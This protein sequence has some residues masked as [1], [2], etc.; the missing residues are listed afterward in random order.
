MRRMILASQILLLAACQTSRPAP[1]R[2]YELIRLEYASAEEVSRLLNEPG[3]LHVAPDQRT[4]SMPVSGNQ[5]DVA[6]AKELIVQLDAPLEQQAT[7]ERSF[8]VIAL[9]F[10]D[11][12]E[13]A[14]AIGDLIADAQSA[15]GVANESAPPIAAAASVQADPRTNSLLVSGKSDDLQRIQTLIAHLDVQAK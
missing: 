12:T 3:S 9:E 10:A 2:E 8:V 6:R 7:D 5:S 13:M 1:E 11:A 4:N 15:A 14:A